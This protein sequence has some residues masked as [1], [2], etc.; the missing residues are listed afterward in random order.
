MAQVVTVGSGAHVPDVAPAGRQQ[1]VVDPALPRTP[2]LQL[3]T[4]SSGVAEPVHEYPCELPMHPVTVGSAE[5]E[6]VEV[7]VVTVHPATRTK[8]ST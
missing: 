6:L 2:E 7:S 3:R 8:P 4:V 5:H 1:Y